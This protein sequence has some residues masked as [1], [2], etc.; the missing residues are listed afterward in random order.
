MK[1]IIKWAGGK[2]QL[3]K[4]IKNYFPKDFKRYVEPFLGGGSMF[5]SIDQK[6]PCI[7]NDINE[8]LFNLYN[9]V[10]DNP[11][12]IIKKLDEYSSV[13]SE[14]FYYELRSVVLQ[15]NIERAARTIFLNKTCFNGLYRVNSKGLYNVPFGKKATCP[16][17]YDNDN[18]KEVSEYLK[19]ATLFNKDFK[20]IITLSEKNDLIYC[21]PPY[22][23]ISSTSFVAYN[24]MKFSQEEQIKLK[25][26]CLVAK[27]KGAFVLV[28]NSDSPFILD[29]YKDQKIVFLEVKSG[30]STLNKNEQM[31]KKCIEEKK[32]FYEIWKN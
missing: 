30:K 7:I 16:N 23:P 11:E 13:Y 9:E 8:E 17:L 28:S 31:I 18:F 26:A 22:E 19:T 32:V 15:N 5:F 27:E 2:T 10:K 12:K 3:I 6:I 1:P 29:L 21:D 25:E 14:E 4:E 20:E 24:K